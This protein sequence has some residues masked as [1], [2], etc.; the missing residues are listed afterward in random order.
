MLS[1]LPGPEYNVLAVT[2]TKHASADKVI[3]QRL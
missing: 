1:T 2:H 3:W